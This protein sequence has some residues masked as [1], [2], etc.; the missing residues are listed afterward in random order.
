MS[1]LLNNPA[2]QAGV[3]PFIVAFVLALLLRPVGRYSTGLAIMAGFLTAVAL[4]VGFAFPPRT[5]THKLVT[6]AVASI[7]LAVLLDVRAISWR[8]YAPLLAFIGAAGVLWLIWPVV[9]RR[10]GAEFW[11]LAAGSGVYGAWLLVSMDSLSA[12]P[13]R[14]LGAALALGFGTGGAALLGASASLGQMGLAL[15]AA[16][17][18]VVLWHFIAGREKAGRMVCVPAG[19]I[20][21]LLGIG[22]TVYAKVPWY[23]L[24]C[25]AAIPLLAR[26]PLATKTNRWLQVIIVCIT[27]SIGAAAALYFTWRSAGGVPM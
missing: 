20:A 13:T 21:S 1:A 3:L 16:T 18:A 11:I 8:V 6:L 17:G 25:L 9:M 10:E 19:L 26:A 27:A 22:A 12:Q 7:P 2:I 4:A 23:A 24:L 5:S 15:G 14:A